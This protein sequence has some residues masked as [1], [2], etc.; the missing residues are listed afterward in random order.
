MSVS[1]ATAVPWRAP[2]PHAIEVVPPTADDER[3]R[4]RSDRPAAGRRR[5]CR[6]R[7]RTHHGSRRGRCESRIRPKAFVAAADCS[8]PWKVGMVL[9]TDAPGTYART[10]GPGVAE[11]RVGLSG[12]GSAPHRHDRQAVRRGRDRALAVV[13]RGEGRGEAAGGWWRRCPPSTRP[14]CHASTSS[15]RIEYSVGSKSCPDRRLVV[16]AQGQGEDVDRR[17]PSGSSV[18]EPADQLRDLRQ[19]RDPGRTRR[20]G[21]WDGT[22]R[23]TR[24]RRPGRPGAPGRR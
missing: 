2:S 4:P 17:R 21:P 6:S 3:W 7:H 11:Q 18:V 22:T 14:G 13:P 5:T 9:T 10:H 24:S 8:P 16:V 15:S 19:G 20:S 12:W 1:A 23:Q